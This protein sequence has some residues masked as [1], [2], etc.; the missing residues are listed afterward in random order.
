MPVP[1]SADGQIEVIRLI[2][3]A[4]D[5]AVKARPTTMITLTATLVTADVEL[6]S[7]LEPLSDYR[8]IE[9]AAALQPSAAPADPD[10][11]MQHTLGSCLV[12]TRAGV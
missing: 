5:S 2:K 3:I 4:R 11:A 1:K 12:P 10:A 7:E 8:L 9:A 6:R